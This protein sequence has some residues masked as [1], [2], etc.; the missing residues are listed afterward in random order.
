MLNPDLQTIV[1]RLYQKAKNQHIE[2]ISLEHLLHA[3]ITESAEVQ[4]LLL[5]RGVSL[6]MLTTLERV[7]DVFITDAVPTARYVKVTHPGLSDSYKNAFGLAE[8]N[9]QP[10]EKIS[11]TDLLLAIRQCHSQYGAQFLEMVV[12]VPL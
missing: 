6:A 3:L 1:D 2:R 11:P 12:D 8:S 10:G 7:L 5:A 4:S 9:C